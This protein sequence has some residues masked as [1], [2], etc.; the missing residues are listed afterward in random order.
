MQKW[1]Q[2]SKPVPVCWF[3]SFSL[4]SLLVVRRSG[5][6]SL[7][8][9]STFLLYWNA[10]K[11]CFLLLRNNNENKCRQKTHNKM[12]MQLDKKLNLTP[13]IRPIPVTICW[14]VLLNIQITD[15]ATL[16][17]LFISVKHFSTGWI[18]RFFGYSLA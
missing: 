6:K 17:R 16:C 4:L 1:N 2:T 5:S 3:H 13:Q 10:F 15:F 9:F 7:S 14:F 8:T 18:H 12:V 11:L